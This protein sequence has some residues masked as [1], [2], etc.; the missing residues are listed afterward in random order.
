MIFDREFP[1]NDW[2]IA[3][4]NGDIDIIK[5]YLYHYKDFDIDIQNVDKWTALTMAAN[6]SKYMMC[7]FLIKNGAD[8]N[9]TNHNNSSALTLAC[10][11]GLYILVKLLID[12]GANL[13]QITNNGFTALRYAFI[14]MHGDI[15]KLLIKSGADI[16]L[17]HIRIDTMIFKLKEI[18]ESICEL[19][20]QNVSLI[21]DI[22]LPEIK[23]KYN[24]LFTASGA[25]LL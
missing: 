20:P 21:K 6:Y 1:K 3:S 16:S 2:F 5:N 17:G 18:Q 22:V 14:N 7:E 24:Y 23:K 13:N 8:V 12:S 10:D 19:Q 11:N 15:I 9:I 4:S 25:G